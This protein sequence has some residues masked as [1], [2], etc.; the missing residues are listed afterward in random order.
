MTMTKANQILCTCQVSSRVITTTTTPHTISLPSS[1]SPILPH[2]WI[3]NSAFI[4]NLI[5]HLTTPS[6]IVNNQIQI[7][8]HHP[9]NL[10]A[11][12]IMESSH[13]NNSHHPITHAFIES[14]SS[15]SN[16][17]TLSSNHHHHCPTHPSLLHRPINSPLIRLLHQVN[18][19]SLPP[20]A[21]ALISHV[22]N[23]NSP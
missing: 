19:P 8:D 21:Q 4:I 3:I 2:A 20:P 22:R 16:S 14:S 10:R 6:S 11:T 7:P 17:S 13:S 18:R 9:T 5:S 1:L 15:L 12:Q 23:V